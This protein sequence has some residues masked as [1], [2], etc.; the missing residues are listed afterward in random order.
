MRRRNARNGPPMGPRPPDSLTPRCPQ[1]QPG[2]AECHGAS[3]RV[4]RCRPTRSLHS[5]V[6]VASRATRTCA[7]GESQIALW[8]PRLPPASSTAS[9]GAPMRCPVPTWPMSWRRS[10]EGASAASRHSSAP[11]SPCCE[12][13]RCPTSSCPVSVRCRGL[14]RSE[15]KPPLCTD[16]VRAHA[17]RLRSRRHS[18]TR[19]DVLRRPRTWS[20]SSPPSGRGTSTCR[21]CGDSVPLR[22]AGATGFCASS[23]TVPSRLW[24]RSVDSRFSP[25]VSK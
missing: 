22:N 16:W 2:C 9:V 24:R 4:S 20:P 3:A 14:G 7:R 6:W 18:V 15:S 21:T 17:T 12:S 11:V 19:R 25:Q 10:G 1:P 23:T 13:P 8:L 5:G